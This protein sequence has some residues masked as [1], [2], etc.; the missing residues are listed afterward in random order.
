MRSKKLPRSIQDRANIT[1]TARLKLKLQRWLGY[2]PLSLSKILARSLPRRRSSRE[3]A[4]FVGRA[5]ELT[6]TLPLI[7][8]KA[9]CAG[10]RG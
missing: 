7:Q 3:D 5:V 6:R 4:M 8:D 1:I 10:L 2:E 9:R